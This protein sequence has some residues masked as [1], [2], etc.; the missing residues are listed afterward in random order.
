MSLRH[1]NGSRIGLKTGKSSNRRRRNKPKTA[2]GY[3]LFHKGE[4]ISPVKENELEVLSWAK[5]YK[6]AYWRNEREMVFID[7][8]YV[9]GKV[10]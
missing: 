2:T 9:I 8:D 6:L 7:T 5:M 1:G 3:A 4:R 10:E